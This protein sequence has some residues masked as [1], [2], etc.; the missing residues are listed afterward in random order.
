MR[1]QFLVKFAG[2]GLLVLAAVAC[3]E[4]TE[5]STSEALPDAEVPYAQPVDAPPPA[6]AVHAQTSAPRVQKPD[7]KTAA[8]S[9][10]LGDERKIVDPAAL[11]NRAPSKVDN[12]VKIDPRGAKAKLKDIA[13]KDAAIGDPALKSAAQDID[14]LSPFSTLVGDA[15]KGETL[16]KQCA[17]CHSIVEGET[18]IGPSL[19]GIVGSQAG[20]IDIFRYSDANG[21]ADFVWTED[22]LYAFIE[23][24]Q[25]YLPGTRMVFAGIPDEQERA[26]IV[27]YLKTLSE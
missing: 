8:T 27:A 10:D 25:N 5:T 19:Y 4:E 3:A 21:N 20:M 9:T 13:L 26:D 15:K 16:F 14:D 18:G 24:P 11:S 23:D 22:A 6:V 2:A 17:I 12:V 1:Y 7:V